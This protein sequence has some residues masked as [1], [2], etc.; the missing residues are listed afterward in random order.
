MNKTV[1]IF[2]VLVFT[3]TCNIFAQ[4][5]IGT[6]NP[7]TSAVLDVNSSDSNNP[8]G[9]L[10]PRLTSAQRDA[11]SNPAE[12]LIIYNTEINRIEWFTGSAWR[13]VAD[14]SDLDNEQNYTLTLDN[15]PLANTS[16][17]VELNE[18][19]PANVSPPLLPDSTIP[20]NYFRGYFSEPNG[21]GQ[22][23]YDENMNSTL[24]WDIPDNTTLYAK[25]DCS[26]SCINGGT[27]NLDVENDSY[28]C[29][30]A[31]GWTGGNCESVDACNL[32]S[33]PCAGN[34]TCV[35]FD[36]GIKCNCTEFQACACC[37]GLNFISLSC[38][39]Q[40]GR[41]STGDFCMTPNEVQAQLS[42]GFNFKNNELSEFKHMRF[43][44]VKNRLEKSKNNIYNLGCSNSM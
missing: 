25:Y 43:A 23:Y 36:G 44:E 34:S 41:K 9:F 35:S 28:E 20:S 42:N 24:N 14:V 21:M 17:E 29:E 12:G 16:I 40:G 26:A 3:S 37:G 1:L 22:Q 8:K 38:N 10:P 15:S 13:S 18:P 2:L 39:S 5:G 19:M 32:L 31:E 27:C 7:D 4:V 30:C 11:I 33:N 6:E